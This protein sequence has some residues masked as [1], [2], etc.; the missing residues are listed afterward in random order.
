[1][2]SRGAVV[3]RDEIIFVHTGWSTLAKRVLAGGALHGARSDGRWNY[4]VPYGE[5]LLFGY[6]LDQLDELVADY[7]RMLRSGG[8][9]ALSAER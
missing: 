4:G 3:D 6:R 5:G 1:M 7:R 2:E 8:A 9:S